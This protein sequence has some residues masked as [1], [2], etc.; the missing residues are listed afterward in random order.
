MNTYSVCT[1]IA[2]ASTLGAQSSY[3]FE[4]LSGSDT[5]PYQ[6]LDGQ[7]NWTEE[8]YNAGNRCGVTATLSYNGT[9]SLRFQE[10]G[11]GF[12]CDASRIN[13]ARWSFPSFSGTETAANFEADM[14]VG[15]WGGSFGLA[16]DASGD[17]TIRGNQPGERG[18]RFLV[19]S[20]PNV[21]LR[22]YAADQTVTQVPLASSRPI[23]GGHWIRVRVV[24]D[25][26]ANGG[27]GA[28]S[29]FVRNITTGEPDFTAVPG[30]Q[31]L[32]LALNSSAVDATNP[33]LWNAVWLHFE[34]ATYG[35]D[36]FRV[37]STLTFPPTLVAVSE[38]TVGS[39]TLTA[40]AG[41]IQGGDNLRWSYRD[42]AGASSSQAVWLTLNFG[43]GASPAVGI[44]PQIPGLVQTWGAS[45]PVGPVDI[46]GPSL[47]GGP[48]MS[49]T[50]PAG[51]FSTGDVIRLQ[52]IMLDPRISGPFPI[53]ATNAIELTR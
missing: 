18:V 37:D 7:D 52:G 25:L 29:L 42:F 51:L 40:A 49:V 9:K 1:A 23:N 26:T 34:G 20:N 43:N 19:G 27:A 8:T 21:G 6:L 48:D 36:N 45:S 24:M 17:G 16:Y 33:T 39:G 41:P 30:L 2:L 22:F 38:P 53:Q 46:L 28:G 47:V 13:D 5:H 32:P 11:P 10:V 3:D 14:R 4:A 12:G 15:Y 35:L 44:T 50:V 31:N